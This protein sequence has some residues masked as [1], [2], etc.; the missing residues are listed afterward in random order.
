MAHKDR[1]LDRTYQAPS[2]YIETHLAFKRMAALEGISYREWTENLA[3]Q[4]LKKYN[5]TQIPLIQKTLDEL[6]KFGEV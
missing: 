1:A 4:E 3:I 2:I 5:A 6:S